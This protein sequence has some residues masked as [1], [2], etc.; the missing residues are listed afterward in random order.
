MISFGDEIIQESW[1]LKEI[2]GEKIVFEQ[3]WKWS[4]SRIHIKYGV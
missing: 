3:L 1:Y 2:M 4:Y